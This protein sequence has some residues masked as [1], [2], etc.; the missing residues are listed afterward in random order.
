MIRFYIFLF[1]SLIISVLSNG[2][3]SQS[4][5]TDVQDFETK[6]DSFNRNPERVI[7]TKHGKCRMNCRSI[8]SLEVD[9]ILKKGHINYV[10]SDT[11]SNNPCRKKYALEGTTRDNQLVRIIFSPCN[12]TQTVVTVIDMDTDWDCDCK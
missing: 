12:D 3:G 4:Q 2:C 11:S 6:E 7:F 8:D 1:L 10:K 9:E 5:N